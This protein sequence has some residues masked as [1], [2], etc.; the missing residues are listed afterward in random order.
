M[1]EETIIKYGTIAWE[2][3]S[4]QTTYEFV[5]SCIGASIFVLIALLAMCYGLKR[6][7][8]GDK[9]DFYLALAIAALFTLPLMGFVYYLITYLLNRDYYVIKTLMGS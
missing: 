1:K 4:K 2:A 8:G 3:A 7:M 9:G 6:K 5:S